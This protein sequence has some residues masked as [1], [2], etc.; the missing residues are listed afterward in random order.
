MSDKEYQ[1]EQFHAL[2][3][4]RIAMD[5]LSQALPAMDDDVRVSILRSLRQGQQ[6]YCPVCGHEFSHGGNCYC[7]QVKQP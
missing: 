1:F 5:L 4:A 3:K 2:S 7:Q 6:R